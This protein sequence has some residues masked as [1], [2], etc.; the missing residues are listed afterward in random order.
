MNALIRGDTP[1]AEPRVPERRALL[2]RPI[3]MLCAAVAG[4]CAPR[5][6]PAATLHCGAGNSALCTDGTAIVIIS[7]SERRAAPTA[8]ARADSADSLLYRRGR[9]AL[10]EEDYERAA[11]LFRQLGE[12]FPRSVHLADALYYQ[13]FALYRLGGTQN[14]RTALE[15]LDRQRTRFARAA[16]RGDG[17]ALATRIRGELAKGGDEPSAVDVVNGAGRAAVDCP[18]D[19]EESERAAALNAL[20]QMDAE[21]AVPIIQKVLARRDACSVGLRRK[22]VFLLSQQRTPETADMIM[23]VARTDPDPEVREQAV[24]WL[25][26]VRTE[27][28][29]DLLVE[30]LGGSDAALQDKAVFALS[31][32]RSPR[33]LKA[34]RDLAERETATV[35]IREQAIFWLGQRRSADNAEFLRSLYLRTPNEALKEKI[36][37]SLSQQRGMGNEQWLMNIAVNARESTEMRKKALFWLGQDRGVTIAGLDSLYARLTGQELRE[38]LIFALSQRRDP[39]AVD[40]LMAIAR[41]DKD[42]EL[43]KKAIFWLGQSRDP[44][45]AQ[46]L[47]QLLDR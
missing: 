2:M 46:F 44:R 28:A 3:I 47:M 43:R 38:Q 45:A 35:A 36:I 15:V 8:S 22:A 41:S 9:A 37:F 1:F 39:E 30:I 24:F 6:L 7:N 21:Q 5:A 16:T 31:E 26:Q 27:R 17:A 33:A 18:R 19:D 12:R 42:P 40:R 13:A 25:S 29:I 20:L 32:Q 34:I 14:L 23:R 10:N 4:L 11:L